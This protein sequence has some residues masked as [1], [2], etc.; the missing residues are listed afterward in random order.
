MLRLVNGD[1]IFLLILNCLLL[2]L[3]L[4]G[5]LN[6][7]YLNV[8]RS[9]TDHVGARLKITGSGKLVSRRV[10]ASENWANTCT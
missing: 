9:A 4:T 5:K 6:E 2:M 7:I 8:D 10:V 1:S 3:D